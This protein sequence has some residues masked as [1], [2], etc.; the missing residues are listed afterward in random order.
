MYTFTRWVSTPEN[1]VARSAVVQLVEC[2]GG[3]RVERTINPLFLHGPPGSGKTHLVSALV[4]EVAQRYADRV[5]EVR[6]ANEVA[7]QFR[8]DIPESQD[9]FNA[10]GRT[11]FARCDLLVIEDFQHL[12]GSL[13]GPLA[14]IIDERLARQRQMVFTA[15]VGPAHMNDL[16]TRL[17]SRLAGG[18]VVGLAPLAPASRLTLL[19]TMAR[20]RRIALSQEVLLWLAEHLNGSV[21][22]LEGA[23]ARLE[24]LA[25]LQAQPLTTARVAEFFRTEADA[26]R[27]TVERITQR[28]GRYFQVKPEQLQSR[29]RLRNALLPRQVSMYLAR[30]LT[31]LSLNEIGAFF[32][33]RDHSTVLHACRKVEQALT[34]D[35]NLSGAIRQLNA[36][37]A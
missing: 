37:L 9:D 8:P 2:L 15:T 31:P 13:A 28:V 36:D 33:G 10:D 22:Q 7:A 12:P 32:G 27:P 30:H 4:A 20:R 34:K 18:L 1:E 3:R 26:G 35:A 23:V 5:I 24:I 14:N 16:P 6:A 11:A 19:E 29:R 25:R 21:R 17:T